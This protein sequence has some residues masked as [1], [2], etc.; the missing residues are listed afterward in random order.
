M[1]VYIDKKRTYCIDAEKQTAEE[2]GTLLFRYYEGWKDSELNQLI[3]DIFLKEGSPT[4]N[5]IKYSNLNH[6][7]YCLQEYHYHTFLL[8]YN[9][10]IHVAY[11]VANNWDV[12]FIEL[13]HLIRNNSK[14]RRCRRCNRL[15][16]SQNNHNA[17][18]CDRLDEKLGVPCS[19]L[20]SAEAY[21]EKLTKNPILQEYQKAYKR[22]YARVRNGK[23]EQ[24]DFDEWVHN[25][26]I[27]RDILAEKFR[28]TGD[29]QIVNDFIT[30]I[31][32]KKKY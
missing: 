23:M 10:K 5:Y 20:G 11:E 6:N 1:I 17:N 31:G 4:K 22:L 19:K 12:I 15:F 32:N 30:R 14:I 8:E 3:E 16:I 27:E 25:I 18:Y 28:Q 29:F 24:A 2:L 9:K 21:R 26:T 13:V 7:R